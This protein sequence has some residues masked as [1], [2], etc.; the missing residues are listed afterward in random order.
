M[1]AIGVAFL[2]V[3]VFVIGYVIYSS[4]KNIETIVSQGVDIKRLRTVTETIECYT[5]THDFKCAD[6]SYQT[7]H[8]VSKEETEAIIVT[9]QKT[10]AILHP[11]GTTT[12]ELQNV[13]TTKVVP[14]YSDAELTYLDKQTGD[15]MICTQT[16]QCVIEVQVKLYNLAEELVDPPY[17]YSLT[18]SCEHRDW[19]VTSRTRSISAGSVTDGGG[20]IKYS[21]TTTRHDVIGEYLVILQIRSAVL[22]SDGIPVTLD[23]SIP[24]V[25]LSS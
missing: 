23:K 4:D 21:W 6:I 13:T 22:D 8:Q 9:E 12:Y 20:G 25:L 24:L 1:K 11:D 3:L 14:K 18:I 10:I 16:H 5:E 19:C 17:G 15:F 7:N 2:L